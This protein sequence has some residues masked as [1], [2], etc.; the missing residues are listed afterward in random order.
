MMW[1]S[2]CTLGSQISI[3]TE[4]CETQEAIR[5]PK[6]ASELH[7]KIRS[8]ILQDPTTT[9][10]TMAI[11][12]RTTRTAFL[13]VVS[14]VLISSKSVLGRRETTLRDLVP[15]EASN[16]ARGHKISYHERELTEDSNG[17]DFLEF[18]TD[19]VERTFNC[20]CA[21]DEYCGRDGVCHAFVSCEE[22]Y[23]FGHPFYTGWNETQAPLTCFDL[24]GE[25]LSFLGSSGTCFGK[26]RPLLVSFVEENATA[27]S[28]E[29]EAPDDPFG[30]TYGLP[31][32][33]KCTAQTSETHGF[34]CYDLGP[35]V[36]VAEYV[37]DYVDATTNRTGVHRYW[38][39]QPTADYV[40]PDRSLT[41]IFSDPVPMNLTELDEL[42]TSLIGRSGFSRLFRIPTFSEFPLDCQCPFDAFCGNDGLCHDYTCEELF[43]FGPEAFTGLSPSDDV[44][45]L[46]CT[47]FVQPD[48]IIAACVDPSIG[49]P[50][51]VNFPCFPEGTWYSTSSPCQELNAPQLLYQRMCTATFH[52]DKYFECYDMQGA[53]L[54]AE[55]ERFANETSEL[56][57][58]CTAEDA[59][60]GAFGAGE[61]ATYRR[62]FSYMTCIGNAGNRDCTHTSF[63]NGGFFD[64]VRARALLQSELVGGPSSGALRVTVLASLIAAAIAAIV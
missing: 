33:R 44:P 26:S 57:L 30:P 28:C 32:T 52:A 51:A 21:A 9:T 25:D 16:T 46:N 35:N 45:E 61:N 19:S 6:P 20:S 3:M 49:F 29:K 10:M 24:D 55:M 59:E 31:A 5:N 23:D 22:W 37:Q 58:S 43:R 2:D 36:N 60:F 11:H 4:S 14:L 53:D 1:A 13:L 48:P 63:G 34:V 15:A 50:G 18:D 27:G 42:D 8:S 7:P 62:V 47:D 64:P 41:I 54:E 17:T 38:G 40:V 39:L 56:G 12:N